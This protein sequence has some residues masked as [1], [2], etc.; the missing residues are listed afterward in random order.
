MVD[1]IGK[2][3]VFGSKGKFVGDEVE[4]EEVPLSSLS[5]KPICSGGEPSNPGVSELDEL[6]LGGLD[7]NGL[8]LDGLDLDS[9]ITPSLNLTELPLQLQDVQATGVLGLTGNLKEVLTYVYAGLDHLS[10]VVNSAEDQ[11]LIPPSS[12]AKNSDLEWLADFSVSEDDIARISKSIVEVSQAGIHSI[13]FADFER[14]A[15]MKKLENAEVDWVSSEEELVPLNLDEGF[16]SSEVDLD[17]EELENPLEV[18][19]VHLK[20]EDLPIV[21]RCVGRW[22]EERYLSAKTPQKREK[23]LTRFMQSVYGEL[24]TVHEMEPFVI[25]WLEKRAGNL[26]DFILACRV[27]YTVEERVGYVVELPAPS[28][29]KCF[30]YQKNGD[31]TVSPDLF[32]ELDQDSDGVTLESKYILAEHDLPN[33][34]SLYDAGLVK[35]V[36]Y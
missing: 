16:E 18:G 12:S 9:S 8:E 7:L 2:I 27:G 33:F 11:G 31:I 26:S 20:Q 32:T 5:E 23:A 34:H 36:F 6:D 10:T 21:P 15:Q 13:N 14:E 25:A 22:I 28:G 29:D 24:P 35:R 19:G 30:R 1:L 3:P 4:F 17:F